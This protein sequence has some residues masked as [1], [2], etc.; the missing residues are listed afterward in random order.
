MGDMTS[1]AST[2]VVALLSQTR[3]LVHEP[4]QQALH[5]GTLLLV[6]AA[7]SW[8]AVI[9]DALLSAVHVGL[10]AAFTALLIIT[11]LTRPRFTLPIRWPRW[12]NQAH[13]ALHASGVDRHTVEQARIISQLHAS[14]ARKVGWTPAGL[15]VLP[16]LASVLTGPQMAAGLAVTG[17][18]TAWQAWQWYAAQVPVRTEM[19]LSTLD[20]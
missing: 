13:A 17:A 18:L 11:L 4:T 20:V 15:I 19:V 7:L 5:V 2:P 10:L 6:T 16:M 12:M 3:A 14:H 8:A 9:G 1:P